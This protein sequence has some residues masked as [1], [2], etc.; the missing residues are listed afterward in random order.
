VTGKQFISVWTREPRP[1]KSSGLSRGEIVKAAV[2]L[3]DAEGLDGLSMRKLG[4][5]LGAGAT[6]LYWYVANKDELLELVY[7]EFWSGMTMPDPTEVSW[8][9]TIR[10]FAHELRRL[11]L[12]HP[13]ATGLIGRTPALGPNAMGITDA[14]RRA[15]KHAGFSG[16]EIDY[17]NTAL[18]AYIFG[19]TIPEVA[20]NEAMAAN[21]FDQASMTEAVAKAASGH[22]DLL[23]AIQ[24]AEDTDPVQARDMAFSFGLASMID[25]L[26]RRLMT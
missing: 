6:S 13:W 22:P 20:W 21:A 8:R 7:D 3:L 24:Q 19:M 14:L 23:E 11:I 10:T 2:K 15:F 1:A 5:E 18:T 9:H 16:L 4:A 26:E 17:A 12:R 25:G